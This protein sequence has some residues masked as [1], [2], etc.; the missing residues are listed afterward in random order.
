MYNMYHNYFVC[1]IGDTVLAA[2]DCEHSKTVKESKN[3]T[4]NKG[5]SIRW[6]LVFNLGKFC[7]FSSLL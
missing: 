5:L 7:S 1:I 6:V 2:K 3:Y 4:V